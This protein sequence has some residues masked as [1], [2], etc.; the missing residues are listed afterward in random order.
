MPSGSRA[1]STNSSSAAAAP[2]TISTAAAGGRP[3]STRSVNSR[4]AKPAGSTRTRACSARPELS[5]T[6]ITDAAVGAAP[7]QGDHVEPAAQR[8][9]AGAQAGRSSSCGCRAAP[10]RVAVLGGRLGPRGGDDDGRR[11]AD[12]G[13]RPGPRR[14]C[15]TGVCGNALPSSSA[16]RSAPTIGA[17]TRCEPQIGHSQ[18]GCGRPHQPHDSPRARPAAPDRAR[19]EPAAG[20]LAAALADQRD[21]IAAAWH[22]DQHRALRQRRPDQ[23]EHLVR[24]PGGPGQPG[25]APGR[26]RSRR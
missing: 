23:L 17:R 11:V 1:S 13:E 21:Q 6:A 19:A 4:A 14:S 7:D 5:P 20:R 9:L 15:T 16:V 18:S 26:G 25:R 24:Q 3:A 2:S 8:L 12:P 10:P 22:L